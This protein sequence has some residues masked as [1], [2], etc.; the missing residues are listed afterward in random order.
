MKKI[1]ILLLAVLLCGCQMQNK[2]TEPKGHEPIEETTETVM[3]GVI[4]EKDEQKLVILREDQ[5]LIH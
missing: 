2:D 5:K 1:G 3:Q 4:V